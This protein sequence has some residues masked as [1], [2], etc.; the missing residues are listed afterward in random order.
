MN[1]YLMVVVAVL[2]L[3]MSA[4]AQSA[5]G[6]G[7]TVTDNKFEV[8][9]GYD[10]TR[11]NANPASNNLNGG[12]GS[13]QYNLLSDQSFA[14]GVTLELADVTGKVAGVSTNA[15]SYM[16][17]PTL[18]YRGSS[19]F[20]PFGHALFGDTRISLNNNAGSL[21]QNKFSFAL[22]G[23]IDIPIGSGRFAIRP[24]Q[25]DYLRTQFGQQSQN[26]FRYEAGVVLRF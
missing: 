7:T 23:G 14:A 13:V 11:V 21:S 3:S 6:S 18:E 16:I 19:W 4:A 25:V 9:A 20:Q 8:A 15:F 22:G 24:L 26:N 1:R 5:V 12:F 2:M 17:G 10:Y